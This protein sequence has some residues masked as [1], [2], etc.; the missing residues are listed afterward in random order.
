MQSKLITRQT[1]TKC[2]Y[3]G[4]NIKYKLIK[5]R[6]KIRKLQ[7]DIELHNICRDMHNKTALYLVKNFETIFLPDFKTSRMVSKKEGK[8]KLGKNIKFVLNCMS[9]YKFKQHLEHKCAEYGCNFVNV[10]EEYTSKC[11]GTCEKLSKIYNNRVKKCP[12]C[13]TKIHRDI[14]GSRNILLKNISKIR[15]R[16]EI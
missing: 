12:Y 7:K 2:G 11:C 5:E 6:N 1:S 3:I 16:A 15:L 14:N 4:D 10:T 13:K 8:T 9:H